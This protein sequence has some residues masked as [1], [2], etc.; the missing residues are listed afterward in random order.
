MASRKE[1]HRIMQG[2]MNVLPP[3]DKIGAGES[4]VLDNW[5]VDQ[6]GV[7]R[8]RG[9]AVLEGAGSFGTGIYHTIR[10]TS[11]ARYSGVGTE[12][13]FG[14]EPAGTRLMAT[15]FDGYPLGMAFYQGSGW[16]MNRSKQKRIVFDQ[17]HNWGVA[18]PA[19]GPTATAAD[20]P[21]KTLEPYDGTSG[22]NH[23]EGSVDGV[24][25][26][27]AMDGDAVL[28]T[29]VLTASFDTTIA[30]TETAS[31]KMVVGQAAT[32]N[33]SVRPS[34]S[35]DT[36][37][38]GIA[39]DEDV[40]RFYL[41]ASDP[42]A[43]K[44]MTVRMVN[45]TGTTETVWTEANFK[46]GSS[47]DPVK[48]LSQTPQSWTE[49]FI[50]RTL[51]VDDFQRKIAAAQAA[52]SDGSG[53]QQA[54]TDLTASLSQLLHQPSLQ[55]IAGSDPQ[56][57]A[58][59]NTPATP[60]SSFD[61]S[62]VARVYVSFVLTSPCEI[63][64][65]NLRFVS[66]NVTA[67]TGSVQYY[68]SFFNNI[69]EDSNP[70]PSSD[71]ITVKGQGVVLTNIPVS[72]DP[73]AL[74]R[75]IYR[76]GGALNVAL[77]VG[78][79]FDNTAT[80]WTDTTSDEE[81]QNNDEEMPVNRTL[82]PTAR[83]VIGPYFS[84]LIAFSTIAHPARN[85]WTPAG[86]PFCFPG[87]DDEDIG[88]WEDVGGDDDEILAIVDHKQALIYYKQRSIWRLIGDPEKAD[89][90]RTNA[91]IGL[92]GPKALANCGAVD[93]FVGPEGVYRFN[94][95]FEEKISQPLD[96]I[97]KG[98]W[99]KLS[100]TDSLPPISRDYVQ[101][102]VLEITNERLRVSYPEFPS[103]QPT[104]V[105]VCNLETGQW[106]REK[107]TGLVSAAPTAMY[108][109]GAGRFL[110]GGFSA[111]G[112]GTLYNLELND[113]RVD[114]LSPFQAVWQSRHED[115]GLPDNFKV[116]SDLEITFE[117]GITLPGLG[118]SPVSTLNVYLVFDRLTKVSLGT[119]SS[120]IETTKVLRVLAADAAAL[121]YTAKTCAVRI[122]GSIQAVARITATYIHYY[123]EER[124]ADTFDSG[125]TDLGIPERVKEVDYVEFYTTAVGQAIQRR[126]H[127]DL[128]GSLLTARDTTDFTSPAGRGNTRQRLAASVD[129]RNF[130]LT[131]AND[132]TGQ[133]FQA[134]QV[135][136]RCRPIGEYIDGTINEYYESPEFS[137][138]PGR[139]GELKDFLLDYDVSGAGGRLELY[140]DLPSH[141][142]ALVRTLAIPYYATGRAVYVFPL[143]SAAD[144]TTEELPAG[145]LFKVRLYPPAGGILRL[146][147]RARFRAR[148]IGVY[149]EG[150]NG[151]VFETQDLDLAGGM[152]IFRQVEIT[153]QTS[154]AMTLQMFTELPNQSMSQIASFSIN[155]SAST[156]RRLPII[157][158]L[159]GNCK[160]ELQ[161][162]K[163]S[164]TAV[165]RILGMKVLGRK[166][167]VNGGDWQWYPIPVEPTPSGWAE[168]Q[169]PVRS[170]PEAFEWIDLPVDSIE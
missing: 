10:R 149:F 139:V 116:Y 117:T 93:Y 18:P 27:I 134:H 50:R 128:P 42:K 145:Q 163:V 19:T 69:L 43:I 148:L 165:T 21:V 154:G 133:V 36:R 51:N 144:T 49:L 104:V 64:L 55:I 85:F 98:E 157:L 100:A 22:L 137:V 63:H 95:D 135:R 136:V 129:G 67:L 41:W 127:S 26:S 62:K 118:V 17:A 89:P 77:R 91:N 65:D 88:N 59:N 72:S 87:A 143:E 29:D 74:G 103:Q 57:L 107:F 46:D 155:P 99:V 97:F 60:V 105:A 61:W 169:M 34:A 126:L 37:F 78:T 66:S 102:T 80:T 31:L 146:H 70:S 68:V 71:P 15:G 147:G 52:A 151:E 75:Y 11:N 24:T 5:R 131:L 112:A 153:A 8:T 150:A 20:Q 9:A 111:A 33:T 166:L 84:K 48:V 14:P 54:V 76:I 123:P 120:P 160:G 38:N 121:G 114:N 53:S 35:V 132:P 58:Q 142:L 159:P 16:V 106:T 101:N 82:P 141:Q 7:L 3:G 81:A 12:L 1:R 162:F 164:G 110:V 23:I 6:Q 86:V 73:D 115:Q 167:E 30:T 140:S 90:V 94:G 109:E 56:I 125:P 32:V 4:M 138:A 113:Y 79:L 39:A 47:W 130:R 13:Y 40:L 25:W 152:G 124:T 119:I 83:G 44:S 45:M 156:T 122:E 161:R 92:V 96:P 168:I 158:R 108:Y 170:T 2:A 28:A